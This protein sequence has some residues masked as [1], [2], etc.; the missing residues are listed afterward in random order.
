MKL[1][2]DGKSVWSRSP[3]AGIKFVHEFT[4]DGG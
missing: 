1:I 3:D 2:A 4:S